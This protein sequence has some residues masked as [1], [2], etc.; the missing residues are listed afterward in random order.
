[1]DRVSQSLGHRVLTLLL[2]EY[3]FGVQI[4][5]GTHP[6]TYVLTL[7]LLEY[8]FGATEMAELLAYK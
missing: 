4:L 8:G 5:G 1:M 6:L 7:L 3:G 2:L